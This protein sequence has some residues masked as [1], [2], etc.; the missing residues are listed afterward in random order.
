MLTIGMSLKGVPLKSAVGVF[1]S[2]KIF[3]LLKYIQD[4]NLN[5]HIYFVLLFHDQ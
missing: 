3:T 1:S 5:H 2:G 4:I